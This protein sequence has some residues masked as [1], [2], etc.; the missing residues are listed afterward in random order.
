MLNLIPSVILKLNLILNMKIENILPF[1][2][3]IVY[4]DTDYNKFY[5]K[6]NTYN[7]MTGIAQ[8]KAFSCANKNQFFQDHHTLPK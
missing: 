2:I 3:L 7:I 4:H 5:N 8:L 1:Y 6:Y